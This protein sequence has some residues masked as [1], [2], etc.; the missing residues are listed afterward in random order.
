[1][2]IKIFYSKK[3]NLIINDNANNNKNFYKN[4]ENLKEHLIFS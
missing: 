2:L 3:I 4:I 1:M